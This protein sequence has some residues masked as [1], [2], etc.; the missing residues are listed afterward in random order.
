MKIKYAHLV[1]PNGESFQ[2]FWVM[3]HC[4]QPLNTKPFATKHDAQVWN[5]KIETWG[6]VAQFVEAHELPFKVERW[7]MSLRGTLVDFADSIMGDETASTVHTAREIVLNA[8]YEMGKIPVP[9]K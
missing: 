2:G 6:D 8:A 5:G 3:D 9:F 7:N 1:S 4:N